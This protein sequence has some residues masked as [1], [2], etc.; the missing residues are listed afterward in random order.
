MSIKS[1]L[2]KQAAKLM[3]KVAS[4]PAFHELKKQ[5]INKLKSSFK[6]IGD[7]FFVMEPYFIKNPQYIKIGEKFGSLNNLRIEAWDEY[8]GERFTPEIIIGNNVCFNTDCHI[9][10]INKVVIGNN[11]LLASRIYISDH[12]HGKINEDVKTISPANRK[13][14]SKGPVIIEDDVWIGEG[15]CIMPGV[16]IGKSSIIGANSVVTKSIPPYSIVGGVPARIL[17]SL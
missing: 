9:G 6:S 3:Y 4:H 11:V 17:K 1:F 2:I 16:T 8:E 12:S 13:L 15:V 10:C 14:F 7:Q 5:E